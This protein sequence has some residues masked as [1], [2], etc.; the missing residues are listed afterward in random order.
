MKPKLGKY[1]TYLKKVAQINIINWILLSC[2]NL[3]S[4]L[5]QMV[6]CYKTFKAHKQAL[7]K[8]QILKEI[9]VESWLL[10]VLDRI[11]VQEGVIIQ[12]DM[13]EVTVYSHN[14]A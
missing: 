8:Y 6:A 10:L 11:K 14:G 5:E 1:V 13:T 12:L 3:L 9:Q 7:D 2:V 4:K